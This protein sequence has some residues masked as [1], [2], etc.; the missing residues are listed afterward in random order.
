[1]F[2]LASAL[3]AYVRESTLKRQEI[4]R[5]KKIEIYSEFFDMIF[6]I[7]GPDKDASNVINSPDFVA[8]MMKF[9]NG[10]M[11]YGSPQVIKAFNQFQGKT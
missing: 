8:R 3:A 1:M 5:V 11:F 2:A 7:I 4:H 6:G 10:I 9:K